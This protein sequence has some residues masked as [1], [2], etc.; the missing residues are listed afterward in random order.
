MKSTRS[1]S[2]LLAVAAGA[3]ISAAVHVV[4]ATAHAAVYAFRVTADWLG[5]TALKLVAGPQTTD[6]KEPTASLRG[7]VVHKAHQLR[8]IKRQSPRIEDSWRMCPSI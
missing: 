8:Q 4:E 6:A 3:L 2:L 1:L 7:F 5:S